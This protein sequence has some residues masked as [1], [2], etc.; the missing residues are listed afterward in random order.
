MEIE[1]ST[2]AKD[3]RL[4]R[5]VAISVVIFSVAA[6]LCNIKD[7]N[8]VQAMQQAQSAS[9]DRW[10]EYQATRTKLHLE[11]TARQTIVALA[12]DPTRARPVLT[13]ADAAIA[14][15]RAEAPGIAADAKQQAALYDALNVHDDQF[16]AADASLATAISIAAVT[17]LTERRR[18]LLAVLDFR[19][20]RTV[21]GA[22]RLPQAA[23]PPRSA[24]HGIGVI[25]QLSPLAEAT[26]K[27]NAAGCP[28]C[29]AD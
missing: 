28:C 12:V 15:Y 11:E 24:E 16:D 20:V 18:L 1:V 21:H 23:V 2:E 6:G 8:I 19:R 29:R 4:N 25:A 7:G 22:V 13:T 27:L 14:K 3:R 10:N 9:I 17:A 26:A 5:Q